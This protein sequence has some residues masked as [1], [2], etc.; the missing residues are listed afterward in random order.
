MSLG[1]IMHEILSLYRL[2]VQELKLEE[3][4]QTVAELT[5]RLKQYEDD[6]ERKESVSM[7]SLRSPLPHSPTHPHPHPPKNAY[8]STET[9]AQQVP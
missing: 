4:A 5:E 9:N 3:S 2:E 1:S 8:Y 6:L 7:Y